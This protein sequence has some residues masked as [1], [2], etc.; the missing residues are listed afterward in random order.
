MNAVTSYSRKVVKDIEELIELLE[1]RTNVLVHIFNSHPLL[2][3]YDISYMY[4]CIPVAPYTNLPINYDPRDIPFYFCNPLDNN[5]IAIFRA[6]VTSLEE[7]LAMG[8]ITHD[9]IYLD[10]YTLIVD[11]LESIEF[12]INLTSTE[13]FD[14][15]VA[16]VVNAAYL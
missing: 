6:S 8:L 5:I 12:W 16:R 4:D 14:E 15:C 10:T 1:E 3:K 13:L 7:R 9:L 11:E 2:K